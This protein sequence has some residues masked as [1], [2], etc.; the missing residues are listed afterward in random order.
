MFLFHENHEAVPLRIELNDA[1]C[2]Q[3]NA[4]RGH[5]GKKKWPLELLSFSRPKPFFMYS[6]ECLRRVVEGDVKAPAK[7]CAV[8][9]GSVD[10]FSGES[11]R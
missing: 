8:R 1:R 2:V 6:S 7:A 9:V 5:H 10:G 3:E 11:S 4:L